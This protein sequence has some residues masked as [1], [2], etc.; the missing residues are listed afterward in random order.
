MTDLFSQDSL[1]IDIR[2]EI[3]LADFSSAGYRPIIDAVARLVDGSLRELFI[4]G[5]KGF[6]KTR[7]ASAIYDHYVKQTQKM[8]ISLH[9]DELIDED[10]HATAL[11]GLEM[12]DLIII[13]DL[14]LVRQNYEWQ[15]GLFHLI[16]RIHEHKKQLLYFAD[17]TARE[18]ELSLHD[19]HTRLSLAP[20]L[21]M[22]DHD[23]IND[24]KILID[25]ILKKKNWRL[26]EEILDY[27]LHEGPRNAGDINIVLSHIT[28]LLTRLSRVQIPKKTITEAKNIILRE[29]FMLEVSEGE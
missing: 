3:S 13:D 26:P 10:P 2:Q 5:G 12:F 19:L 29:T 24:R 20:M 17:D 15:E 7:L 28:P 11:A 1:N 27:L 6:G 16:N 22:P 4:V 8:A 18:L 25:T 21:N 14:Q 9:L 23:D